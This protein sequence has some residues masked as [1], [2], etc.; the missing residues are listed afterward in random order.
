[1]K[2]L[3][4]VPII[5]GCLL[6]A[7][8]QQSYVKNAIGAEIKKETSKKADANRLVKKL[9]K[10][11]QKIN[12]EK[13][14]KQRL[15]KSLLKAKKDKRGINPS[16]LEEKLLREIDTINRKIVKHTEKHRKIKQELD[17]GKI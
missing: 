9:K 4:I 5:G 10:V 12:A 13:Q 8:F 11:E 17:R 1:M 3:F 6:G 16:P 7:I 14:K 2:K 15:E